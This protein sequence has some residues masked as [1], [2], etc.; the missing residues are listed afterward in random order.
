MSGSHWAE[1]DLR[2]TR[3]V[4]EADSRTTWCHHELSVPVTKV[5]KICIKFG[6]LGRFTNIKTI[7][8]LIVKISSISSNNS[9]TIKLDIFSSYRFSRCHVRSAT[10]LWSGQIIGSEHEQLWHASQDSVIIIIII[11]SIIIIK[12][13]FLS[14]VFC[15]ILVCVCVCVCVCVYVCV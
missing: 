9:I 7:L 10:I 5:R 3:S 13:Y 6:N 1:S 8:F 12:V 15:L 2:N 14:R 11:I 4:G